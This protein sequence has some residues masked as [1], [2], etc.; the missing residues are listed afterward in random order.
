M[1]PQDIA[2]EYDFVTVGQHLHTSPDVVRQQLEQV[3]TIIGSN[4]AFM[5]M[6][7]V[8]EVWREMFKMFGFTQIDRFLKPPPENT[9]SAE[10]ENKILKY[11]EW[12]E[13]NIMDNHEEHLQSHQ[14][15]MMQAESDEARDMFAKHIDETQKLLKLQQQSQPPPQEQPGMQ[16]G[17]GQVPGLENAIP[18]EASLAAGVG[19]AGNQR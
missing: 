12:V 3:I 10:I 5:Q 7:E 16:G 19:G 2:G 6:T 8:Y 4:P 15:A 11:G 18:T 14:Q 13:P 9:V 17:E 1:K